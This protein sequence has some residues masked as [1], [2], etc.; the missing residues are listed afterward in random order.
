LI[1]SDAILQTEL[2]EAAH[3]YT[4]RLA[5]AIVDNGIFIG[6]ERHHTYPLYDYAEK[7]YAWAMR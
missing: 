6:G 2:D 3:R 4:Q 7:H 1:D 5:E